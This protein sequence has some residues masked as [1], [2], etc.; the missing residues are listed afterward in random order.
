M[1]RKIVTLSADIKFFYNIF[2]KERKKTQEM[3]G[4]DNLSQR[5]FT[6]MIKGFKLKQPKQDLSKVNTRIRRKN[7]RI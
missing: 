4:I 3:I 7:V 2:E 6:K 1:V 5:N